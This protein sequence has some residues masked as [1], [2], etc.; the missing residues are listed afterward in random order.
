V[1]DSNAVDVVVAAR[2]SELV[3][4]FTVRRALPT[5]QRRMIG[6]FVFLD[7]MGPAV[8]RDGHGL[9]VAPH[10]HIGL[11]TVTYLF[12]GAIVHRDSLGTVQTIR[13]SEVNWMSAGRGIVHSE[14]T[15]PELRETGVESRVFGIQTWVAL[16]ARDEESAPSFAH[17]AADSL[18]VVEDGGAR[19]RLIAGTLDGER[20][21]VVVPAA[22]FYAELVLLPGARYELGLEH[23]ERGA[24]VVEGALEVDDAAATHAAAHLLVFQPRRAITLRAGA[25]GCRM[26][27]LGGAALDGPRH[28]HWNFVSSSRE[29]IE[30]AKSDWREGRFADVPG[31][32]ERIAGSW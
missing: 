27:L 8:L 1:A 25:A 14:R 18:P 26:M 19:L 7:E 3:P 31:E 22:M 16:P 30:Q 5:I 32:T 29:R 11:A 17:H 9:D 6:P 2:T 21:P 28:I 12:D 4:G 23:E 13:P 15:P 10:P 20:S 24:Y